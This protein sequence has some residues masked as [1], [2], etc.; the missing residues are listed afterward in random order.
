M[1]IGKGMG[2][3]FLHMEGETALE[4]YFAFRTL[5]RFNPWFILSKKE[6]SN[7]ENRSKAASKEAG[8]RIS[9]QEWIDI[10]AGKLSIPESRLW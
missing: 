6:L 2:E 7:A 9:F 3:T 10:D 8:K 5:H 4:A 1:A